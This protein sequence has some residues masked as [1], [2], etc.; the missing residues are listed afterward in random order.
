MLLTCNNLYLFHPENGVGASANTRARIKNFS[1]FLCFRLCL[2][3][4]ALCENETQ[5]KLKEISYVW[6]KD[7]FRVAACLSFKVSPG[8]QPF[9]GN[10][11]RIR[12]QIKLISLSIVE[13]QDS[14]RNRDKQQ[15][16]MAHESTR[17]RRPR[18]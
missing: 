8:A 13:H 18:V 1:F 16:E 6:P 7:H 12:M 4:L 10:E 2:R 9:N 11:L 17:S 15:P 14:L 3:S 5:H